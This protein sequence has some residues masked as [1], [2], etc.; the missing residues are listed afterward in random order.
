LA[1]SPANPLTPAP[2]PARSATAP[3]AANFFNIGRDCDGIRSS[4]GN[5]RPDVDT[6]RPG[7]SQY[8]W[9]SE[10]SSCDDA[11]NAKSLFQRWR[12]R[13][14]GIS[15]IVSPFLRIRRR[16][17]ET[18][19][20]LPETAAHDLFLFFPTLNMTTFFFLFC[21]C[22]CCCCL[23]LFGLDGGKHGNFSWFVLFVSTLL[24]PLSSSLSGAHRQD[25]NDDDKHRKEKN[26]IP[27]IFLY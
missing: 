5:C 6:C 27:P 15:D 25:S 17:R 12:M 18:P 1:P 26:P 19:Q 3:T 20:T 22:C 16:R 21:R 23:S 4:D 10:L 8:P 9:F 14:R 13:R 7:T 2:A 11:A 24:P